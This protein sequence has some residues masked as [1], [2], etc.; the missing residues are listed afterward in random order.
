LGGWEWPVTR[1]MR[2]PPTWFLKV[3]R[4]FQIF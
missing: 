1:I 2:P 3:A 4:F